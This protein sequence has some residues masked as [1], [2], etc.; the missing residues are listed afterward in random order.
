MIVDDNIDELLTKKKSLTTLIQELENTRRDIQNNINSCNQKLANEQNILSQISFNVRKINQN[1]QSMKQQNSQVIIIDKTQL[2]KYKQQLITNSSIYN[3]KCKDKKH[4]IYARQLLSDENIKAY[5]VDKYLPAINDLLNYY[6]QR[7]GSSLIFRFNSEFDEEIC[8]KNK[9]NFSYESFSEG[10]KRK[11]DLAILF[12]FI[13]FLDYKFGDVNNLLILDEI[14]STLDSYNENIL[15]EILKELSEKKN[16]CII[17][18]SHSGNIESERIDHLY[19]VIIENGFS[20]L[21]KI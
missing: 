14:S 12:T 21:T 1:L 19:D 8:S 18:I 13:D 3:D 7:F 15:Y 11:I 16:K 17:T 5:V 9:E 20:K 2:D 6:L 10:G 4:Y